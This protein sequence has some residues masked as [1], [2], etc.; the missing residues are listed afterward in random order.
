LRNG[1][2]QVP[3]NVLY[4]KKFGDMGFSNLLS[5][6]IWWIKFR[7]I[8]HCYIFRGTSKIKSSG[9]AAAMWAHSYLAMT[10]L[11]AEGD[12]RRIKH[13]LAPSMLG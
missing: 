9:F 13:Y 8:L 6:S 2:K 7:F 12:E 10:H 4:G 5:R 1:K 3:L 11:N